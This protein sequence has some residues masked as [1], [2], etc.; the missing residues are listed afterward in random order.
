MIDSRPL[1]TFGTLM[2]ADVL[3]IV[4]DAPIEPFVRLSATVRGLGRRWVVDDHYPVLVADSS[5]T[6]DGLLIHGLDERA[7][8]RILFF[9][10]EEFEL[11]PLVVEVDDKPVDARYFAHR[12]KKPV[13]ELDWTLEQWQLHTKPDT[14]HR[15]RRYMAHYGRLTRAE[16]DEYW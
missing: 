12:E 3:S 16:A 13:S 1:F 2:D 5:G 6:T 4:I 14:L 11:G 7:L 10:G 9:E 15:V 8:E